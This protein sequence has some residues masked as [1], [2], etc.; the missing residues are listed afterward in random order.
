M[1]GVCVH[2]CLQSALQVFVFLYT[3]LNV[4]IVASIREI[5]VLNE[6]NYKNVRDQAR[7]ERA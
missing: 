5:K 1:R 7:A 4:S 6:L 3:H 2:F